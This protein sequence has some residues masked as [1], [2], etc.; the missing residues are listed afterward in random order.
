MV[1]HLEVQVAHE[2]RHEPRRCHVHGVD[3]RVF[4]KVGMLILR[5][6]RQ[7]RVVEGKVDEDVSGAEGLGEENAAEAL[8]K[9]DVQLV[10]NNAD[11]DPAAQ[12]GSGLCVTPSAQDVADMEEELPVEGDKGTSDGAEEIHL[13]GD[14]SANMCVPLASACD[15]LVKGN[16]R[17]RLKVHVVVV[18]LRSGM[19][20]VV[21][22]PPP[23]RAHSISQSVEDLLYFDVQPWNACD[24]V[25]TGFVHPPATAPLRYSKD[26][27]RDGPQHG[28][29]K[30]HVKADDVHQNQLREPVDNVR[31]AGIEKTFLHTG[32]VQ[33]LEVPRELHQALL[34]IHI[35]AVLCWRRATWQPFQ[36]LV[37]LG[38]LQVELMV[39]LRG[40]AAAE[41]VFENA[42]AWMAEVGAV[43][44]D[45]I[46]QHLIWLV[47]KNVL[48][49]HERSQTP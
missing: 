45:A 34:F 12:N 2:P 36:V 11:G 43:V 35:N 5:K 4:D 10:A 24:A 19:M 48:W 20:L 42:A 41:V 15:D 16:E 39:R 23:R 8:P 32:I 29:E 18:L 21:L 31:P 40:V 22:R 49:C 6:H 30:E 33:R 1:L 47:R 26:H 28:K 13:Q 44:Q 7:M 46:N 37:R 3:R 14:P 38:Q 25:V 17:Q 9:R 27:E